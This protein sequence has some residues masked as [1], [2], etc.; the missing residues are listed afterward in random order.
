MSA[1]AVKAAA[2]FA[3]L[4]ECALTGLW[5]ALTAWPV[6]TAPA[7]FAAGCAHLRRHLDGYRCGVRE[8]ASDFASSLRG[9]WAHG[10]AA[11]AALGL[12]AVDAVAVRSGLPGGTPV[13]AGLAALTAATAV[14]GLRASADWRPGARWSEL[15]RDARSAALADAGGSGLLLGGLLVV[16]VVTW[17]LPPLLVPAVGCL[18]GAAVAVERRREG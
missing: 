2:R 17:Q 14:V 18:V 13:L 5:V 1:P 4:A 7:A 10:L 9:S 6:V 12:L 16:A 11:L 3:L 8:Y 15:L